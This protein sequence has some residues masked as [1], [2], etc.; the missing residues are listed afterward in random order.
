VHGAELEGGIMAYFA[1]PLYLLAAHANPKERLQHIVSYCC[2]DVGRKERE[3]RSD[4]D[5]MRLISENDQTQA[6][7]GFN[8]SADHMAQFLGAH[9][10]NVI[11]HNFYS[12]CKR[13]AVARTFV[14]EL[15]QEWGESPLVFIG[16]ELLWG[17]HNKDDPSWREFSVLCAVSSC[18]GKKTTPMRIFRSMLIPRQLGYKSMEM[19]SEMLERRTDSATPLKIQPLRST[20]DRLEQKSLIHRVRASRRWTYFRRVD[21]EGGWEGFLNQI[22]QMRAQRDLLRQHRWREQELFARTGTGSPR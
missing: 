8:R 12:A 18:L 4:E 7:I 14:D 16:A 5:V 9:V 1:F 22:K 17:C 6:S 2:A 21:A 20:L 15:R 19:M 10:L 13:A 3:K 11:I